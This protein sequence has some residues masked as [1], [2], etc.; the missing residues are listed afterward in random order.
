MRNPRGLEVGGVKGE[1]ERGSRVRV[2]T[3]RDDAVKGGRA[4]RVV[5][6]ITSADVSGWLRVAATPVPNRNKES[7]PRKGFEPKQL[8]VAAAAVGTGGVACIA[9][10]AAVVG[11]TVV[12][13]WLGMGSTWRSRS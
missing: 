12:H 11:V 4:V 13:L 6:V 10:V 2:E 8:V 7:E 9:C 5:R 1:G 3:V